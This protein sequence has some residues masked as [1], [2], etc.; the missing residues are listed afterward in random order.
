MYKIVAYSYPNNE[1]R[2]QKVQSPPVKN[3][4]LPDINGEIEAEFPRDRDFAQWND[5]EKNPPLSLGPNSKTERSTTGYGSLPSRAT[6]FGLNA[7]RQL[8]RSGAAMAESCCTEEC[9][10]LTGT[11]PGSTEDAFRAIASYSGYIVNGLKAWISNYVPSKLDFYCWEYQKRGALHLHYC[12]HVPTSSDRDAIIS[13]FHSWWVQALSRVGDLA[14]SDLFRKNSRFTHLTDTS[15]VR[16]VA[17]VCRKSPARYLAKYLSKSASPARGVARAF[18]PSRWWGTS[19]PLKSLLSSLTSVVEIAESGYHAIRRKWED[20]K[21][22]WSTSEGVTYSYLHKFGMGETCICYPVSKS[23]SNLLWE[24]IMNHASTTTVDSRS[25]IVI[26][27]RDLKVLRNKL[28]FLLEQSLTSLSPTFQGLRGAL[29]LYLSTIRKITPSTSEEP[30]KTLLFWAAQT[31]DIRSL[32][33][34]TPVGYDK[35]IKNTF[36]ELLDT[37]EVSI[38]LVSRQGWH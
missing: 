32:C 10:F 13:G 14:G 29:N 17:E 28:I 4:F 12:V 5:L 20:V 7:K 37:L 2:I 11:L 36:Q 33:A 19:R 23:E 9:L 22:E 34:F 1:I 30:M 26:P 38:E 3:I 25:S 24:S 8:I 21:R 27:S 35:E 15:K 16:A 31:S 18:T 6:V